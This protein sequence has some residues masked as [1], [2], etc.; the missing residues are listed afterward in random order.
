VTELG[1]W[2]STP[3]PGDFEDHAALI[4]S[5]TDLL[6]QCPRVVVDLVSALSD[7]VP[8]IAI[9]RGEEQRRHAIVLL[10]DW[11]VPAH[12]IQF[13]FMPVGAWTRDFSPGFVRRSDGRVWIIDADYPFPERPNDDVVPAALAS[14]LRV[15]RRSAPLA[16]EGGNLLSNGWGTCLFT[17]GLLD[18]NRLAGRACDFSSLAAILEDYYG[19]S[20]PVMLEPLLG[21]RT[22]HVDMFAAFV[23]PHVA[24]VAACDPRSDEASAAALDRN[25]RTLSRLHT[26]DRPVRVERIPMPPYRGGA[27]RTYTNVLFAS[28]RLLVPHYADVD[29]GLERAALAV[30]ASLLPGWEVIPIDCTEVI[31]YG[32]ALR[33]LS[34]HVPWLHERFK[35]DPAPQ[36]RTR[37]Q[38]APRSP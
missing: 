12:R 30:Y 18:V 3:P 23:S 9:V 25:A 28:G 37:R 13:V 11:G 32:G 8:L 17:S 26:R 2:V 34:A 31:R 22:L 15:P 6:V 24:V 27:C 35:N 7:R 20:Q 4:L 21:H 5:L 36:R 33:C 10:T 16:L 19:F 38:I 29:P 1:C 14:L